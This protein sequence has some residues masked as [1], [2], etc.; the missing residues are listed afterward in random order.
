MTAYCD[1]MQSTT[2]MLTA[3]RKTFI[4]EG[5]AGASTMRCGDRSCAGFDLEPET[6]TR[7]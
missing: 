4:D 1:Q 2:E 3:E 5:S 6:L 7:G